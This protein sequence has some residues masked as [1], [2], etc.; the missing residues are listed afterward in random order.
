MSDIEHRLQRLETD[1][2]FGNGPEH[3]SITARLAVMEDCVEKMANNMRWALRLILGV[4]A[5][6][7]ATFILEMVKK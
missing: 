5:T 4:F 2:W 7:L 6:G 1:M 3:L